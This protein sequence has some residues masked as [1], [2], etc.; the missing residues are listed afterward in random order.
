MKS[1]KG[2]F[3]LTHVDYVWDTDIDMYRVCYE[4]AKGYDV[5][6]YINDHE[7]VEHWDFL[8]KGNSQLIEMTHDEI[9]ISEANS[10]AGTLYCGNLSIANLTGIEYFTSINK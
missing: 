4:T 3:K 5:S 2:K 8:A 7:L 9:E 10:F 6:G 1:Y